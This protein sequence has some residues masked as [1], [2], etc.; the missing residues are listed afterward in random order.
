MENKREKKD[1]KKGKKQGQRR[2]KRIKSHKC[3]FIS[4]TGTLQM[5]IN[6]K[7]YV[8]ERLEKAHD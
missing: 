4:A 2:R 8:I 1:E 5:L 6:I 3:N 7:L